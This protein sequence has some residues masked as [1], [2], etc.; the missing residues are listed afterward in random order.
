MWRVAKRVL[1]VFVALGLAG[2]ASAAG[3]ADP[4]AGAEDRAAQVERRIEAVR[5][6]LTLTDEQ[7]EAIVPILKAGAEKQAAVLDRHGIVL[8]GRAGRDSGARLG[9]RALRELRGEM[10]GVR[11]ET[12]EELA[13][14]LTGEQVAEY[15]K[16]QDENR[17]EMR[18][19]FRA[20]R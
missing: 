2:A 6:R 3:G 16:I 9:L 1:G 5:E 4:E 19:R 15:R 8:D 10:D 20:A 11:A 12:I 18:R 7:A 13:D 14:V 17:S